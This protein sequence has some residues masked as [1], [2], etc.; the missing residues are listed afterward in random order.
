[1]SNKN[2]IKWKLQENLDEAWRRLKRLKA[3]TAYSFE[4]PS[5]WIKNIHIIEGEIKALRKVL[6]LDYTIYYSWM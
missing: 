2:G 4:N 1:M 3:D 5:D 6:N